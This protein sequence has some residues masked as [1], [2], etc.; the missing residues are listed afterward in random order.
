MYINLTHCSFFACFKMIS[1]VTNFFICLHRIS[2]CNHQLKNLW[3]GI[4]TIVYGPFDI[5]TAVSPFCCHFSWL[6]YLNLFSFSSKMIASLLISKPIWLLSYS[7]CVNS[8]SHLG[9]SLHR[10]FVWRCNENEIYFYAV[11]LHIKT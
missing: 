4:C 6:N 9:P 11:L 3:P 7:L 10:V 5:S 1:Y 8:S 2:Q